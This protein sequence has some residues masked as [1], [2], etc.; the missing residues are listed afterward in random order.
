MKCFLT[1]VGELPTENPFANWK[2][3]RWESYFREGSKRLLV[4]HQTRDISKAESDEC[5]NT[6]M[7]L[8]FD[9]FAQAGELESSISLYPPAGR[10]WLFWSSTPARRQSLQVT[11]GIF[12]SCW[13]TRQL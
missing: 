10:K 6:R 9:Q 3:T 11:N 7:T 8:R 1:A 5:N 13:H 4:L 2:K 12:A